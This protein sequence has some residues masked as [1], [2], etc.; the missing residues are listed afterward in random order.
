MKS[1]QRAENITLAKGA[2][3]VT[4][5]HWVIL[6]DCLNDGL[7]LLLENQIPLF[8]VQ[9]DTGPLRRDISI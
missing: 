9:W 2:K 5:F 6:N 4:I 8:P 1:C 7:I 3:T